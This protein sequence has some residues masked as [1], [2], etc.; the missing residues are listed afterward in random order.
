MAIDPTTKTAT[1]LITGALRK[2]GQYA[3]GEAIASQD[4]NDA[5]DVLNAHLDA[6]SLDN[7]AIFNSV[8][9][10]ITL[11]AGQQKYT[12]GNEYAGTFV[13]TTTSSS[14]VI[15]GV[16]LPQTPTNGSNTAVLA[17]GATVQGP[18]IPTGSTVTAIGT[19]TVT[20]SNPATGTFTNQISYTS[21]GQ[22]VIQ[23]PLRITNA[24]S[25]VTTTSSTVDFFCDIKDLTDYANIGLKSQPGPWAKF[26]FYNPKFPNADMYLWPVPNQAVEF[27]FWS[28][29]V[30]QSVSL[31][32][33]LQLPQGYY[34]YLQ[35]A[36]A[37][38]LC[39][40]FGVPISEDIIRLT[41]RYESKIKSNNT[42]V[43]QEIAIDGAL[44][45]SM[46]NDAGWILTG[47][48]Q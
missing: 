5:L 44:V 48:F 16:T 22:I 21:P 23:R 40:E 19:N 38:L 37:E 8:E 17:L 34:I 14:N 13:G 11:T 43:D 29:Q 18:G 26:L 20:I 47:G 4:L 45:T 6:M 30:L 2:T 42:V 36:L 3:P 15:T 39:V 12:V 33:P 41:K 25:R 10:V 1:D 28:D 27:H 9:N 35:F 46:N 31:S 24:Y 7:K 32:T